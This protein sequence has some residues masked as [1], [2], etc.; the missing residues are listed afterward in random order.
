MPPLKAGDFGNCLAVRTRSKVATNAFGCS[1][2]QRCHQSVAW[3]V[4]MLVHED[5]ELL[6]RTAAGTPM[7]DMMRRFWIPFM[8]ASELP[9]RDG[10]PARVRLLGE[11][12]VAFRDSEGRVG[13]L[14]A[15]CPHRRAG[16]FF[17]RN[18]E[19]GLRC[20]YHGWKFDIS[21]TCVE[22]PSEPPGSDFYKRVRIKSYPVSERGGV[23]WAYMGPAGTSSEIPAFEWLDLPEGQRYSSRWVQDSNYFQA[24]EGDIDSAHVSFLHRRFDAKDASKTSIVGSIFT[25]DT[26]PK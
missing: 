3:E 10:A 18:E 13:L 12:L 23:L 26:A 21:G 1:I 8:L 24:L 9:D 20:S 4:V 11:D 25:E 17:G 7:G 15:H 5:N 22:V 19:C 2:R 16:L 14:D 6:T